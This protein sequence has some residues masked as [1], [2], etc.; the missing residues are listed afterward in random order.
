MITGENVKKIIH[1]F[2]FIVPIF[3]VILAGC[4]KNWHTQTDYAGNE[5]SSTSITPANRV[6]PTIQREMINPKQLLHVT[7][8]VGSEATSTITLTSVSPTILAPTYSS[9]HNGKLSA[10]EK[11]NL[12]LDLL[13]NNAGCELPCWWGFAPGETTRNDVMNFFQKIGEKPAGE[14]IS[15]DQYVIRYEIEIPD[16]NTHL[17]QTYYSY[18]DLIFM[19]QIQTAFV[20]DRETSYS[21]S[22][23]REDFQ[24]YQFHKILNTLGKPKDIRLL[25][26]AG[27]PGGGQIP[28]HLLLF[29]PKDGIAAEYNGNSQFFGKNI[30]ICPNQY[31]FNL[32]LWSS[33][34]LVQ[35]STSLR[36]EWWELVQEKINEYQTIKDATGISIEDFF[37]MFQDDEKGLLCFDTPADIWYS[38]K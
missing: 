18:H 17:V 24:Q 6:T 12:I 16:H 27:V 10:E 19:I 31:P 9:L 25:T 22:T 4:T 13:K 36:G 3:F 29:Y 11:R 7:E 26:Y 21:T 15:S 35:A 37:D 23:Y 2:R 5:I 32:Y 38:G 20:N 1:T 8:S 28:F 33:V 34:E 30:H 14:I